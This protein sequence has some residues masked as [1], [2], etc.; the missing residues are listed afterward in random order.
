M[1]INLIITVLDMYHRPRFYLKY[2]FFKTGFCLRVQAGTSDEVPPGNGDI[3]HSPKSRVFLKR[4]DD[5]QHP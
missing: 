3:I 1:D 2:E 4:L 5:G